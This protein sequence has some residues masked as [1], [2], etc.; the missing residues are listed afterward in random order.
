LKILFVFNY[1]YYR[2]TKSKA[3]VKDCKT[4]LK[5]SEARVESAFQEMMTNG[6]IKRRGSGYTLEK[7][8]KERGSTNPTCTSAV[9]DSEATYQDTAACDTAPADQIKRGRVEVPPSAPR[10][11][12]A[13]VSQQQYGA[14]HKEP[15][16]VGPPHVVTVG[17]GK[18]S[19][20]SSLREK[21]YGESQVETIEEIDDNDETQIP[22]DEDTQLPNDRHTINKRSRETP[23]TDMRS[24]GSSKNG[25]MPVLDMQQQL[26]KPSSSAFLSAP[27]T[28]EN[29]ENLENEDTSPRNLS[30]TSEQSEMSLGGTGRYS[31]ITDPIHQVLN[32]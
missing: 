28:K 7:K 13:E 21:R 14:N 26:R 27:L 16:P 1:Y 22:D 20:H 32:K 12:K 17:R 10:K 23:S 5:L 11:K 25:C 30:Q 31:I 19:C 18:E 9:Q 29:I 4:D 24:S 6:L 15:V 8:V 3:N 2:F